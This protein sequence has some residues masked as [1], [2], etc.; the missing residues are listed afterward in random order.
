MIFTRIRLLIV[1]SLLWSHSVSAEVNLPP[2][3]NMT[4]V[5]TPI[6]DSAHIISALAVDPEGEP[7]IYTW[8]NLTPER[9]VLFSANN[10][11]FP[12]TSV[13]LGNNFE[14]H[15][16]LTVS[17]GVHQVSMDFMVGVPKPTP[18]PGILSFNVESIEVVE[19]DS[20]ETEVTLYVI[21][22][23]GSDGSVSVDYQTVDSD[24][25][26][27]ASAG[28]DYQSTSGTLQWED[29]E[30]STQTI[31]LRLIGDESG[32]PTESVIL[33]L[34]NPT[35]SASLDK[36]EINVNITDDDGFIVPEPGEI[37]I[38]GGSSLFTEGNSGQQ[39]VVLPVSRTNGGQG[40]VSVDW[41]VESGDAPAATPAED[42]IA[43]SGTLTWADGDTDLKFIT[44]NIV[45]DTTIEENESIR[46]RL[47]NPT[48]GA[49]ITHDNTIIYIENDDTSLRVITIQT[50][51]QYP[52]ASAMVNGQR[53]TL[54]A[55]F[56]NMSPNEGHLIELEG[57]SADG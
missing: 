57:A 23:T 51:D 53:R 39:Q 50:I 49:A 56:D 14:Y 10:T 33:R 7:I 18:G 24:P 6:S 38:T 12:Q 42:F 2:Y 8:S 40:S 36:D 48:N 46:I 4:P 27:T 43:D 26:T 31:T 34:S 5:A 54:P 47:S 13:L 16:R 45:G 29:G 37:T 28:A 22:S 35:G 1:V 21:R 52:G 15:F 19:G 20:G 32:E 55:T 41:V 44:I 17:D 25:R 11:T 3:F 9:T 30:R